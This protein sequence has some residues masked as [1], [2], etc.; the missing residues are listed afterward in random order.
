M[1]PVQD[2]KDFRL[3]MQHAMIPYDMKLFFI[4]ELNLDLFIKVS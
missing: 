2:Q 1:L 3:L 4:G